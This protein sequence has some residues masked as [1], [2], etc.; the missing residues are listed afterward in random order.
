MKYI[1]FNAVTGHLEARYDSEIHGHREKIIIDPDWDRPTADLIL[2]PGASAEVNGEM[3]TNN[4]SDDL[5]ISGVLD[6]SIDAPTISVPNPETK[7]PAEAIPVED[8][9]F[10]RTIDE[11]DG[12]WALIDEVVVKLPLPDLDPLVV[13]AGL[14]TY[15]KVKRETI[16]AGGVLAA[17]KWFHSD[18]DSRIQHLGLKDSARD[19]LAAGGAMGDRLKIAGQDIPWKTMDG[20]F[21]FMTAQIA[22]DIVAAVALLDAL[23]HTKAEQHKVAMEA[24][25]DPE[26]YNYSAGWP[27]V[28]GGA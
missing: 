27:V 20:T 23:A 4:S 12:I 7:I 8:E 25:Q 17:G 6:M 14:W 16:K 9:I 1:L 13:K 18:V 21:V 5:I 26:L 19:L 15:I 2:A 3:V 24:S 10:R 22:F 11:Q 28:F